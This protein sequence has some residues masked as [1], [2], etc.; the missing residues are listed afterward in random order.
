MADIAP[1]YVM[2]ILGRAKELEAQGREIIHMEVG[3]PDF[4]TPQPVIEA[5]IQALRAGHTHYTASLGIPA[6]RQAIADF[7]LRRYGVHIPAHRIAITPGV[8]S[9][10]QLALATLIDPGDE[11]MVAD[12]GYP[13]NRNM[14]RLFEGTT[15][16]VP[17]GIET[18]YQLTPRLITRHATPSTSAIVLTTPSNPTG[19]LVT[20]GNMAGILREAR[21]L[22]ARVVVDEIY[23][24]L[25]YDDATVAVAVTG[26]ADAPMA[27]T[28]ASDTGDTR[29]AAGTHVGTALAL[30]DDIFLASGF[31]KYFGMTG[32]RLGWMIVPECFLPDIERLAQNLYLAPPTM[33]QYAALT[34]FRPETLAILEARRQEFQ[35]RRDFLLPALEEIGFH[36]PVK[37]HGAFY[38][39]ADCSPFSEDSARF[40]DDLLENAGVAITPGIDFGDNAPERHVRFAYTTSME[41]LHEGVERLRRYLST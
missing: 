38:L 19:T 7:Y 17:V 1:F 10:L 33:A 9:A 36:I 37:P 2:D 28:T 30:S 13:C 4:P 11:V 29:D 23:L 40:A 32:W 31:S 34:A 39:Y 3:E 5:G 18:A 15:V 26:G 35:R 41:N 27:G 8:S 25:V 24:G 22:D 14:I 6:L 20:P 21:R 12:P 16:A